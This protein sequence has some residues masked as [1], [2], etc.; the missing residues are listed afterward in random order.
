M[1]A[2]KRELVWADGPSMTERER[3]VFAAKAAGYELVWLD[4]HGP[5]GPQPYFADSTQGGLWNPRIDDGQSLRLAVKLKIKLEQKFGKDSIFKE[6]HALATYTDV[7]GQEQ[8]HY[9]ANGNDPYD[10]ARH[11]IFRAAAE[12]GQTM[13]NRA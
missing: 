3:L 4:A 10:A 2:V 9:V 6:G 13:E 1:E 7:N 11:A 8:A 5:H 12:I